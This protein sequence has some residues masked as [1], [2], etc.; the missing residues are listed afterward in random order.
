MTKTLDTYQWEDLDPAVIRNLEIL[1]QE[2][3]MGRVPESIIG[4]WVRLTD[5]RGLLMGRVWWAREAVETLPKACQSVFVKGNIVCWDN[6]KQGFWLNSMTAL[7]GLLGR[8]KISVTRYLHGLEREQDTVFTISR[9][10]EREQ[11]KNP[12]IPSKG[13]ARPKIPNKPEIT[14]VGVPLEGL[15]ILQTKG[16]DLEARGHEVR[17]I[18]WAF[19]RGK[20]LAGGYDPEDVYQEVMRGLVARNQG[21][22]PWDGTK[23][24]FGHYV[25]L[26]ANG[27][28][29]N[30]HK[31]QQQVRGPEVVGWRDRD[32]VV[33]DVG[34]CENLADTTPAAIQEQLTLAE[35]LYGEN[36]ATVNRIAELL[37][38]GYRIPE[39]CKELKIKRKQL[40]E[41]LGFEP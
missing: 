32:G 5:D 29:I 2:D 4:L 11:R 12:R 10:L 28:L 34:S 39:I 41:L 37:Q 9:Q 24:S 36:Q 40:H 17:K 27:V 3:L 20:M 13:V 8:A 14:E 15:T 33:K 6:G 26:V 25:Y 1:D 18:L 38:E 22:C 35:D 16:I 19:F 31:K 21:K 30:Y 7:W 23:S